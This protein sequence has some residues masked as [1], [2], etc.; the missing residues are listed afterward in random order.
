[1]T[2]ILNEFV[3]AK[4]SIVFGCGFERFRNDLANAVAGLIQGHRVQ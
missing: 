3:A 1:M 4:K 2:Q